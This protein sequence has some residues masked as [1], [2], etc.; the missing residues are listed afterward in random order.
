MKKYF[1]VIL[2]LFC[3]FNGCES[4]GLNGKE[5]A[6]NIDITSL[7]KD[8]IAYI[9]NG[10]FSGCILL[11]D[12][13]G[14]AIYS[15]CYGNA[16]KEYNVKNTLDTKFNIASVGKMI[17]GIAISILIEEGKINPSEFVSK[18]LNLK[19]SIFEQ[20]TVQQLLTHTS[21]LGDYFLQVFSSPY[22]KSY[23]N[24]DDYIE[25]VENAS[26]E[27][28]PGEKW[29]YSNMG[30]LVLGLIIESITGMS[31]RSYIEEK[32]FIPANMRDSGF[33]LYD[34]IIYNRATGYAFDNQFE[35]WRSRTVMPVL[36]GTSSGGWYSTVND[37][38]NFM[39]SILRNKIINEYYVE[40]AITPKPEI[41]SP[42][43]GYGFFVTDKKISH[44]G[45]GMG[46]SSQVTYYKLKGYTLV[47]LC[48]YPSGSKEIEKIFDKYL[49]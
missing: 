47:I 4:K 6:S 3:F 34:E 46:I 49:L 11:G 13:Y 41:N 29:A 35:L 20:I 5:K 45:N 33:W 21:G 15:Y 40:I 36:R 18:Y 22:L 31:Y 43:Y 37:L 17:T 12:G 25:I 10:E 8:I 42:N 7:G 2:L 27:F 14:E 39:N 26:I 38:S 19:N 44:G 9:D 48:N 1:L 16:S 23:E 32:I 24:L 30:Y 28:I